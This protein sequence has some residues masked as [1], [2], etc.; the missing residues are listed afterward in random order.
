MYAPIFLTKESSKEL[1][2]ID[3]YYNI[4]LSKIHD[5]EDRLIMEPQHVNALKTW[6]RCYLSKAIDL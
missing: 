3:R 4:H 2:Q 6:V 5:K 1:K